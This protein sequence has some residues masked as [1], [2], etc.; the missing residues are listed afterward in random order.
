DGNYLGDIP[1]NWT[2]TGTLNLTTAT[3]SPSFIFEP[4]VTGETGT[5]FARF[6]TTIYDET[7]N[8]SVTNIS[9]DYI[10]IED[11]LGNEIIFH[12]MDTT[13][14]LTVW[15]VGY[16]NTVGLIGPVNVNWTTTP[17][18]DLQTATM[19][20]SFTFD[21]IHAPTAGT[22]EARMG[23][24]S[25]TIS[26]LVLVRPGPLTH[27]CIQHTPG[28]NGINVTIY[29]M[30]VTDIF[31]MYSV[32]Y[33]A[34][35]NYI[36]EIPTNW[37]NTLNNQTSN[38]SS[39]FSFYPTG[40]GNGTITAEF[41]AAITYTT[42][43]ITVNS[44]AFLYISIQDA[45]SGSGANITFHNMTTDETLIMYAVAYDS[46]WNFF[47]NAECVW[48]LTGTLD[49]PRGG[50]IQDG[51]SPDGTYY[52]FSPRRAYTSGTF[53]A[54]NITT[55]ISY[56]TNTI[57][58]NPGAIVNI[59]IQYEPGS[60]VNAFCNN[61][62]NHTMTTDDTLILWACGFDSEWNFVSTVDADWTNFVVFPPLQYPW[63]T[64]CFIF[65]PMFAPVEG[66]IMAVY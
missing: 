36:S 29:T 35:W 4:A 2:T 19:T 11:G 41:S 61:V 37:T 23:N 64:P 49:R 16:N 1:C 51:P 66:H 20:Q 33:D 31:T 25:D 38:V 47:A 10:I 59:T 46:E 55:F 27:L 3:S 5:I 42:G 43:L 39:V 32:G 57:W 26:G 14:T 44:N 53:I 54:Y 60:P 50:M 63:S 58:V 34:E 15:A 52:V 56:E 9:I 7:G 45:P 22:I 40:P 13:E 30:L 8:I 24:L 12:G 28:G 17:S 65:A 62:T 18:L 48:G 6:N 21:P